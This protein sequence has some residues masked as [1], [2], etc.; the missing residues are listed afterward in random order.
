MAPPRLIAAEVWDAAQLGQCPDS[1]VAMRLGVRRELVGK[2]RRRRGI[3]AFVG[4][5]L[6]QDGIPC[7]S[8]YEAMYD[9]VLHDRGVPHEHEVAFPDLGII[10]DLSVEGRVY[11]IAGMIGMTRYD[12]RQDRKRAAYASAGIPVIWLSRE[13]VLAEYKQ[14]K[15]RVVFR[16][17]RCASCGKSATKIVRGNC[18]PCQMKAWRAETSVGRACVG[19]GEEFRVAA[20][21][22]GR[23]FCSRQCYWRSLELSWP[24]WEE[25]D[26]MLLDQP[27][28][29][30]AR[31]LGVSAN[32]LHMRLRRR[33]IREGI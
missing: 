11:E 17:R 14:V 29:G 25:L 22:T 32:A 4:L 16:E 12:R 10:A 23:K 31:S 33:R 30:I 28:A 5:V 15:T 26:R 27:V 21:D 18:R 9:A 3:P 20:A 13:D 6:R 8:I 7:R 2:E 1:V 24:P 19:C